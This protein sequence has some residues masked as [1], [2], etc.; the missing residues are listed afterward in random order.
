V[1]LPGFLVR[2]LERW[3]GW[4]LEAFFQNYPPWARYTPVEVEFY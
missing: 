3:F 4:D 1:L 2:A